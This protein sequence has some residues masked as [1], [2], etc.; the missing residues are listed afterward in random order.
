LVLFEMKISD[1]ELSYRGEARLVGLVLMRRII[2]AL[3][4][5]ENMKD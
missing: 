3:E 5:G 1:L 2:R 4:L